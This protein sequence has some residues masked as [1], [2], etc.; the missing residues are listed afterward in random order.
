MADD[1]KEIWAQGYEA[2]FAGEPEEV[3]A[4]VEL[5]HED[6]EETWLQA[7]AEGRADAREEACSAMCDHAQM[8]EIYGDAQ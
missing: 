3:P 1:K 2:G 5:A 4:H 6:D 7:W 8:V